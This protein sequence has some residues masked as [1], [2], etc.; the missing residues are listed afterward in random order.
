MTLKALYHFFSDKLSSIYN[1]DESAIISNW[2]FESIAGVSSRDMIIDPE[3]ELNNDVSELLQDKLNE[4]LLHKPVQYV[5]GEAWFYKLKFKVNESVLIPRPETEELVHLI[6]QEVKQKIVQASNLLDIGTGSG[7]IAIA[8]KKN[9]VNTAIT[10]I[11][12]S[13]NALSLA[14]QNAMFIEAEIN[15]K[16]FNFLEES[17]WPTLDQFDIIVSNP[18]YIPMNEEEMMD[19]HVTQ[20]EPHEALFVPDNEPLL[21]YEKIA[22]FGRHHLKANGKIFMETHEAYAKKVANHFATFYKKVSVIKDMSG[23]ERIVTAS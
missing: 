7:C 13:E 14:K 3:K 19:K 2:I 12:V 11:D 9:L 10:A 17:E 22:A 20:Y 5:I 4:L 23:K 1:A 6:I 18:P 21:F 15:F 16:Q 8:L